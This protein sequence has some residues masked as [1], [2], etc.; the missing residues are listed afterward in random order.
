MGETYQYFE[1]LSNFFSQFPFLPYTGGD[2]FCCSPKFFVFV[3]V[4]ILL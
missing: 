4:H 2:V 1:Q 3:S